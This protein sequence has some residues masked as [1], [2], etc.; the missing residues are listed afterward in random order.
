M[1]SLFRHTAMRNAADDNSQATT[2]QTDRQTGRY[3]L[4]PVPISVLVWARSF[5]EPDVLKTM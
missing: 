4:Y 2:W 3:P 5:I 1:H